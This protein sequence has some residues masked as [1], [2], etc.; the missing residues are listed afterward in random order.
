MS[1]RRMTRYA[2]RAALRLAPCLALAGAWCVCDGLRASEPKSAT[3][4]TPAANADPDQVVLQILWRPQ[5]QFAGYMTAQDKGFFRQ[6]GLKAVKLAWSTAGDRPF[7]RLA[8][9]KADFCTGWLSEAI[10]ERSRGK[11][12]VHLAQV[13]QRSSL[14]LVAWSK[15]GIVTPAD[16]TGKRVGLWGGNFDVQAQAFFRKYDIHPTIIPQS[17][18]MVPFLRSAVDVASAMHY[19]EYH[20]LLESGVRP[21]ELRVFALADYGVAFPED[22][23]YCTERTRRQR[24]DVCAAMVTACRQGWQYALD[25]EDETLETIMQYCREAGVRTNRNHQRWMLR[26]VAT[27]IR[28]RPDAPTAPWG[29]LSAKAF[30]SVADALVDQR[31][32]GRPPAYE[33]FHQP[34][35][36]R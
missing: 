19:N 30:Q 21:E 33:Q 27:A 12:L 9:G 35:G 1:V 17:T 28:G 23:I 10:V 26:S 3:S 18:S 22:G 36:R 8:D 32:I 5:A 31:L 34:P 24:P 6:S 2:R 13:F 20:T 25:H 11:P 29:S 4:P 15:S 16:M 7:D 14:T